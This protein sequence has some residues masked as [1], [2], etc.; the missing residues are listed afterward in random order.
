MRRRSMTVMRSGMLLLSAALF[1][2]LV[3]PLW[4]TVP[5]ALVR[6]GIL[7]LCAG[8]YAVVGLWARYQRRQVSLFADDLCAALDAMM[9]GREAEG[10]QPYE[11]SLTAKV[12][13]KLVQYFDIMSEGKRQ[14]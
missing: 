8:I 7:A 6:W 5:W 11:D 10:Y 2:G 3:W 12:E 1:A 9:S 13:G 4:R 14:S